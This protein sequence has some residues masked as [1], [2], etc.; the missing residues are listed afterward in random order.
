MKARKAPIRTCIGCGASSDKREFVRVV[1]TPSGDVVV[2][3][4]G[5]SNGR[6]AYVC[7]D[8]ECF[9]TAVRKRRFSSA[10]RVN[11]NEDDTDRLREAFERLLVG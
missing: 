8:L 5:K 2:D 4:S 1:R 7:A 3:P 9:E 6:G 10:L 11:M